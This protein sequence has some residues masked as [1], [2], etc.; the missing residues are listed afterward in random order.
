MR[1][2]LT[3]DPDVAQLLKEEAHRRRKAF[4]DV[5]NDAIR[6]GLGPQRQRAPKPYRVRPHKARLL[7]GID[8]AAFNRLADEL[9]DEALIAKATAAR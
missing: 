1:T 9:D 7:P 4:K 5:V 3:L 6:R 8:S 2:T